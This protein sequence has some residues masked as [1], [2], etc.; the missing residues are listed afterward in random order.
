MAFPWQCDLAWLKQGPCTRAVSLDG[1]FCSK[2]LD[3]LHSEHNSRSINTGGMNEKTSR[4]ERYAE[5]AVQK[6]KRPSNKDSGR[7]VISE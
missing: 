7:V 2:E 3:G 6:R 4:A 1:C 5:S